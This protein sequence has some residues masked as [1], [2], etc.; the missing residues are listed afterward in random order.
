MQERR[1]IN[2]LRFRN[3]RLTREV[4]FQRGRAFEIDVAFLRRRRVEVESVM[5]EV[6]SSEDDFSIAL[7]GES[8]RL[9]EDVGD[10]TTL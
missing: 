9:V 3:A 5:S 8:C 10:R 4:G 6:N 1:E 2:A 7:R